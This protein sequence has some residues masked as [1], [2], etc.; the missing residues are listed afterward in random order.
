MFDGLS[1]CTPEATLKTSLLSTFFV[2][3][4]LVSFFLCFVDLSFSFHASSENTFSIDVE[5]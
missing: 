5:L 2:R 4:C 3:I 1:R